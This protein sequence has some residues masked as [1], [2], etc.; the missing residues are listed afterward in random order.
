MS[1]LIV[2]E[3]VEGQTRKIADFIEAACRKVGRDVVVADVADLTTAVSFD[4][5]D[6][7]ILAA[8]VHER[9]HP[10]N[11]EAFIAVHLD[12]LDA[13]ATMMVSVSLKAAFPECREEALDFLIE[14]EFRTGLNPNVEAL[15]AGAIRPSGYDYYAANIMKNVVL[16]GQDYSPAEGEREF[17]DWAALDATLT[18]FLA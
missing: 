10:K 16:K 11:F 3:T 14:M 2:F 18:A 8:P 13:C 9:R 6:R 5:V 7:V 4:G 12:A 1:V 15:V 17:T